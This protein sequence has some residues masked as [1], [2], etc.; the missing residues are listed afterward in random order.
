MIVEV[1]IAEIISEMVGIMGSAIA[2]SA[3]SDPSFSDT[4]IADE[5]ATVGL[6]DIT[7]SNTTLTAQGIINSLTANGDTIRKVAIKTTNDVLFTN[8]NH[9]DIDKTS[10]EEVRYFFKISMKRGG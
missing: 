5:L 9:P 2:S 8:D 10:S 6:T 3:S 1:G 4:T 7:A